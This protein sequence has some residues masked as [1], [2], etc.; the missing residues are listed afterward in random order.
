[1]RMLS[2]AL[3]GPV[4]GVGFAVSSGWIA[5]VLEPFSWLDSEE[6]LDDSEPDEDDDDEEEDRLRDLERLEDSLEL[7]SADS[8]CVKQN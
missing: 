8:S 1:M 4:D 3:D 7:V 5:A 2:S 6:E